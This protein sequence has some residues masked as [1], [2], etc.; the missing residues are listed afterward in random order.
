MVEPAGAPPLSSIFEGVLAPFDQI[1][2]TGQFLNL[3]SPYTVDSASF[4][5]QLSQPVPEPATLLL[6]LGGLLSL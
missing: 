6:M 2:V 4:N 3:T 1:A 5:Y